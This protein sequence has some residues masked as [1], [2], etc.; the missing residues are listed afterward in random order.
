MFKNVLKSTAS[1]SPELAT[2]L[3]QEEE[4]G[5]RSMDSSHL[6]IGQKATQTTTT[7]TVRIHELVQLIKT[8]SS[9]LKHPMI[10]SF[11]TKPINVNFA[12]V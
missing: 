11:M 7:R 8:S 4:S 12:L 10:I 3:E 5:L 2:G 6:R 1:P 9:R